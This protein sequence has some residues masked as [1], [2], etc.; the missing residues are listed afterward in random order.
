MNDRTRRNFYINNKLEFS[1]FFDHTVTDKKEIIEGFL[2]DR[3]WK[4]FENYFQVKLKNYSFSDDL[5]NVYI[6]VKEKANKEISKSTPRPRNLP[7]VQEE[8]PQ[9]IDQ[10]QPEQPLEEQIPR[11]SG[12]DKANVLSQE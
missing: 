6:T 3:E 7:E 9:S 11:L 5:L 2:A 8:Q 4:L 10:R 12:S 1:L